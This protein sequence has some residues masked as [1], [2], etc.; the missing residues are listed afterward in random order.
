MRRSAWTWALV[1]L[2]FLFPNRLPGADGLARADAFF[3]ENCASCH[4]DIDKA[5][6]LDL[7]SLTY[8]PE[9]PANFLTWVKIHDRLQAGEMPPKKKKRPDPTELESPMLQVKEQ[10]PEDGEAYRYNKVGDALDVSHVQMSRFMRAADYAIREVMSSQLNRPP[11]KIVRYYARDQSAITGKFTQNFFDSFPDRGTTPLIGAQAQPEV[12]AGRAPL[13]V[14]D[15]NPQIREQEAVGW[16]HSYYVGAF[17]PYWNGFTAPVTGRYRLRINGYTIWASPGGYRR[18]FTR[19]EG[20]KIGIPI[21]QKWY[22]PNLD[23]VSP[24]RRSEPIT[25]YS[26]GP[27]MR[28]LAKFDLPA[29]PATIALDDVWLLRSESLLT[30]A[31]RFFR[32]RP[33]PKDGQFTNPLA[34]TDGQPGVA[35]KWIEVEGPL[36]DESSSAGY[37]LLFGDLPIKKVESGDLGVSVAAG[38]SATTVDTL[39]ETIYTQAEVV[40]L[41]PKQDAERLLRSFIKR[42]YR[43]PVEETEVQLFLSLIDSELARGR[44]FANAMVAGYTAVLCS[45][46]FVFLQEKPG[47]L[48]DYSLATRLALFLCNSAPD[49]TLRSHVARGELHRPDV[50]QAE[51]E[52][53]LNDPKARR[54]TDAFLDYWIDLRKMPDSDPSSKLY[55]EYYLDESLVEASLDETQLY[56]SELVRQNLPARNIVDSNFTFANERLARHYGIP[57]VEGVAMRRVNLPPNSPRGGL[58]TQASVLKVTANGTTTS[59]VIRGH[60]I[61]ERILGY[62]IPPPPPVAAV[63]PD[64]R[65]AVTIREQLVKHRADSSCASCHSKMDPPGF[66]LENFDVMGGWRDRY[67][68]ASE[69]SLPAVGLGHNGFPF[70]FHYALAVD[71]AGE[72]PDGRKFRDIRDFKRLLLSDETQI[73]RNLVQ[74]LVI[75]ATGAPIRF[76]D[77]DQIEQILQKTKSSDYGVRS[78]IA[79]IIQSDFFVSK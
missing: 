42:A 32:S 48:D 26:R 79:A 72:L 61:T 35:F 75:Y 46:G 27:I 43:R 11:T 4:N 7:T 70:E 54:F 22:L 5:G 20:D 23:D 64:I 52:R 69:D 76:I 6:R 16:V 65:G 15:S 1:S 29:Q 40:S 63:V 31:A 73:A 19:G 3:D 14:G 68:G 9:N 44:G 41:Q 34:Q 49:E 38:S 12:H 30:D 28:R 66:A 78:I 45:P 47:R 74:Q 24:G 77:R 71:S 13:T 55:P 57:G 18:D 58:V 53:L 51:T 17:N 36:Y 50:V 10:L 2:V 25:V 8:A 56:F 39:P 33:T 62:Q 67:R 59:P 60:F 21:P 37:R